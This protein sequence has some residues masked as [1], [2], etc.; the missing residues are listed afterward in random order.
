MMSRFAALKSDES[1]E[2]EEESSDSQPNIDDPLC[3]LTPQYSVQKILGIYEEAPKDF[4]LI[5]DEINKFDSVFVR[6]AQAPECYSF[7][8]PTSEINSTVYLPGKGTQRQNVLQQQRKG[9]PKPRQQPVKKQTIQI[10]GNQTNATF[11]PLHKFD[12][13]SSMW[14]YKDPVDHI[15][16]PY[17]S[18]KMREWFEKRYFDKTLL[19]RQVNVEGKF[20]SVASTFPDIS[21][22]FKYDTKVKKMDIESDPVVGKVQCDADTLFSFSLSEERKN[23]IAELLKLK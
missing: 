13:S 23:E 9:Q 8:P 22:A 1:F 5:S 14:L 6:T 12:E 10:S 7:T 21:M 16:G 17:P 11:R 15:L 20:Q 3:K 18:Y 19:I 4:N 2:N